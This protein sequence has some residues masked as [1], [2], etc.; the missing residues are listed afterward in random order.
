MGKNKKEKK[1]SGHTLNIGTKL[2]IALLIPLLCMIIIG[3]VSYRS[4]VKG[5]T[6]SYETSLGETL[7]MTNEYID[8]GYGYVTTS[9]N[10]Y[11]VDKELSNYFMGS[12]DADLDKSSAIK[13]DTASDLAS[14]KKNN[15]FINNIHIIP[16]SGH[17]AITTKTLGTGKVVD[18]YLSEYLDTAEKDGKKLKKWVDSHPL[19]DEKFELKEAETLETYQ[20]LSLNK[21]YAVVVDISTE[22]ISSLFEN[23]N[24]GDNTIV[25]VVTENGKEIIRENVSDSAK[26]IIG[27]GEKVFYGSDFYGNVMSGSETEG[28]EDI[29]FKGKDYL[30]MYCKNTDKNL[31]VCALIPKSTITGQVDDIKYVTAVMVAL[32]V[33]F[34]LLI[35]YRVISDIS[36]NMKQMTGKLHEVSKGNLTVSAKAYGND[37]FAALADSTNEMIKNTR[38]LVDKV[39]D[40]SAVLDETSKEVKDTSN[41]ISGY[42][43]SIRESLTGMKLGMDDQNKYIDVCVEKTDSLVEGMNKVNGVV[44][45]VEKIVSDTHLLIEKAKDEV[46][47]LGRKAKETDDIVARVN[48]NILSLKEETDVISSFAETIDSISE[49]TNLLSLNAYIEAARA[50]ESGRGFSVVAEEIRKLA[51]SSAEAAGEITRKVSEI[52]GQANDSVESS[53]M[54]E[55]TVALQT[56][57]VGE[58][59]TLFEQMSE[60][61]EELVFGL[62]KIAETTEKVSNE[63]VETFDSISNITTIVRA[64]SESTDMVAGVFDEMLGDI[65]H[66]D[67]VSNVLNGNMQELKNEIAQFRV[68]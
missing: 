28:F 27:D 6:N 57:M 61:M 43:D 55:D 66:L 46:L 2:A 33:L 31:T 42:S 48:E 36:K 23:V 22:G 54:A 49:Q 1:N 24:L 39:G 25:G 37:E 26:K 9:A 58:I 56:Q 50:G 12:Y 21:D 3:I 38:N 13:K 16:Q 11:V 14:V 18:G 41:T 5:I 59:I 62:K 4:A 60:R 45:E 44:E 67:E 63:S 35:G 34:S 68:E 51:D 8:L 30:F 65:E 7:S 40:A 64:N 53:Q 19:I 29:R 17:N 20:L 47:D 32:A 52:T 15:D 10:K